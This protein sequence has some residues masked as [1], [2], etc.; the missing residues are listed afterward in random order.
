MSAALAKVLG[1]VCATRLGTSA[2]PSLSVLST[3][4]MRHKSSTGWVRNKREAYRKK[5]AENA[6]AKKLRILKHQQRE[7]A[8]RKASLER[9]LKQEQQQQD[10]VAPNVTSA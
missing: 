10:A 4:Q 6:E 5:C 9:K 7:A 1:R 3:T 8:L 2:S